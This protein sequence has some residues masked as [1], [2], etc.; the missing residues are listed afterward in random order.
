MRIQCPRCKNR[1]KVDEAIALAVLRVGR[2][3]CSYCGGL[4][5][6]KTDEQ[7]RERTDWKKKMVVK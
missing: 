2:I 5:E 7:I 3:V 1:I 4:I 6:L